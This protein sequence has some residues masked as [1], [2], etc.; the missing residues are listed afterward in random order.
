MD[1][2]APVPVLVAAGGTGGHLFPAEALAAALAKRG[3][4]VHLVTDQRAARFGGAFADDSGPRRRQRDVA[5]AQS[6]RDGARRSPTLARRLH[7]GAQ[8]DRAAQAR[9]RHRLR[10]LSDHS[11]G[12]GRGLARRAEPHSRFQRRH[13][14]RQP[15]AGAARHRDRHDFSRRVRRRAGSGGQGD[16]DRQSGAAG[17]DRRRGGALS[18]ARRS[19]ASS[20][21]R[22]QPGRAHHGR[23]RARRDRPA[24][25]RPCGRGS[26]SCSR[27]ARRI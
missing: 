13:R 27:R 7:S 12:P 11:A 21:L 1:A 19:A 22:R 10:R 3:I 15:P 5:F 2:A 9:G 4:A 20:R 24:R 25:C 6:D 14:P 26:P 8:A 18:G 17:G 23:Y 16:A